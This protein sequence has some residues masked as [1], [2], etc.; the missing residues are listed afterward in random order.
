LNLGALCP[1][2][3][4]PNLTVAD[5]LLTEELVVIALT[6]ALL[7]PNKVIVE[8]PIKRKPVLSLNQAPWIHKTG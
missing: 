7:Y 5:F 1:F 4:S 6:D 8:P 2:F 3:I